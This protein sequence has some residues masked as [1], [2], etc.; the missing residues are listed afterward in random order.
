MRSSRQGAIPSELAWLIDELDGLADRLRLLEAP[1][2]ETLNSTVAKLQALVSNIQAQLDAYNASRYTNAQ[3]DTLV[4]GRAPVSHTHDQAQITGTWDKPVNNGTGGE[5]R[6]GNL[7]ASQAPGFNITATRVTAWLQ[8][9]DGRLGTASS[10]RRFKAAIRPADEEAM[11]AILDVEPKTFYYREEIR[12][13]TRE[14]IN[15]GA[16]Y[17]PPREVGFIAEELEAL[18]LGWLTFRDAEG[19]MQGV[20]YVMA[21]VALL[22]VARDQERRL[23]A[24][25]DGRG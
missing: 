21:V 24:L 14:R 8:S 15:A 17:T 2:G 5:V 23:R 25:E 9:S 3:I 16:D 22:A 20:E 12:R 4:A 1:S 10:S 13:R 6:T 11:L 19:E 7:Y 18:G